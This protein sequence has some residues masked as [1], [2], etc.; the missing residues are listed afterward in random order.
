MGFMDYCLIL[1]VCGACLLVF[2]AICCFTNMEALHLEQGKKVER[3]F[4]VLV[5]ALVNFK[6]ILKL[7]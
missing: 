5:A 1:S 7:F 2:L 3:G 4:E 6:I